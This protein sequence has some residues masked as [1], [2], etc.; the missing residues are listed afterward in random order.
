MNKVIETLQQNISMLKNKYP[1][2]LLGV[3]GSYSRGDE[4][5]D[6]DLDVVYETLPDSY[7]N[8]DN[9]L[10]LQ[11]ELKKITNL[12]IDLVNKKYMNEVVWMTAKKDVV[13]VS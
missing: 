2:S 4:T 3:Y 12:K 10:S 7:L 1:I 6:S 9:Y 13:Y 8:L 11:E 5:E